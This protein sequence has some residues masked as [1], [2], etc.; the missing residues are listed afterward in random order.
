MV[1]NG[2]EAPVLMPDRAPPGAHARA[3]PDSGESRV[4][5]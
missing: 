4:A 5:L 3:P 2:D 1:I